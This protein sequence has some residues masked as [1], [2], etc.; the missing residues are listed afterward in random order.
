MRSIYV[1]SGLSNAEQVIELWQRLKVAFPDLEFTYQWYL[2]GGVPL[3]RWEEVAQLEYN[4]VLAADIFIML[5]P[6][7]KGS[8]TELG[9]ALA[10]CPNVIVCGTAE[11]LEPQGVNTR[12]AAS[13]YPSIFYYLPTVTRVTHDGTIEDLFSQVK[14]VLHEKVYRNDKL[15]GGPRTP[16]DRGPSSADRGKPARLRGV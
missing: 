5:C 10:T 4:G 14:E 9:I 11:E 15:P 7:K 8:H 6:G 2:Q 12:E 13:V 1:G 3:E 16:G